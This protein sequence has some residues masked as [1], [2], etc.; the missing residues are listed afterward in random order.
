MIVGKVNL[1]TGKSYNADLENIITCWK[2]YLYEKKHKVLVCKQCGQMLATFIE[3]AG[4]KN[5]GW[6]R[7]KDRKWICHQCYYHGGGYFAGTDKEIEEFRKELTSRN[8][9]TKGLLRR[10]K[11]YHPWVKIKYE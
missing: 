11:L 8:K 5:C 6:H 4:P 7:D 2:D 3:H 1:N 10:Y 9:R